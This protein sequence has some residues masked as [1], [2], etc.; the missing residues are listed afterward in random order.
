MHLMT[1][2]ASKSS[3]S[4]YSYTLCLHAF[5]LGF[6]QS[7]YK[8]N[9]FLDCIFL[10]KKLRKGKVYYIAVYCILGF[11]QSPYKYNSFLDCTFVFRKVA[12]KQSI[13]YCSIGVYRCIKHAIMLLIFKIMSQGY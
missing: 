13:L 12:E 6:D 7:P 11:D 10:R 5:I 1:I 9:T 3:I 4:E 2:R 8:Y